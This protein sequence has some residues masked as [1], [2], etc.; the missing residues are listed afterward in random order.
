MR[1]VLTLFLSF[2]LISTA[3]A[4]DLAEFS[5][6][7]NTG[8]LNSRSSPLNLRDNES[9]DCANV[10]F[11]TDGAILKRNGSV[12]VSDEHISSVYSTHTIYN[13]NEHTV[14]GLQQFLKSDGDDFLVATV[15]HGI[16]KMDDLDGIWE[17]ISGYYLTPGILTDFEV[18]LDNIIGTNGT[19]RPWK[20]DGTTS[21]TEYLDVPSLLTTAKYVKLFKDYLFLA[22][23]TV[24]STLYASRLY[25]SN[26]GSIST[27]T[28]THFINI[29]T[30]DGQ[31]I[32][33]LD[34]FA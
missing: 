32:T 17:H 18:Y 27:W 24:D 1:K 23:V 11:D 28:S 12:M 13:M 34:V 6:S 14:T 31:S 16:C 22:N 2:F 8:G 25:F 10:Y 7:D 3:Y 29:N 19:D 33:G 5:L 21:Y 15:G 26:I 20:W 4:L 30:N 9:P